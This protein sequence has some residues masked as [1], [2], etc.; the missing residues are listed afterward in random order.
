LSFDISIN[1]FWQGDLQDHTGLSI[2]IVDATN[3]GWNPSDESACDLSTTYGHTA[4]SRDG[5]TMR[6][7]NS[8]TPIH[9]TIDLRTLKVPLN[10]ISQL[11]WSI[12]PGMQGITVNYQITNIQ[13][14]D[15]ATTAPA[16]TP[17][18]TTPTPKPTQTPVPTQTPAPT[19]AAPI[20]PT[21]APTQP[22]VNNHN[23]WNI[24]NWSYFG[25]FH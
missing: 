6:V 24:L 14:S 2:I 9:Y 11:V 10:H 1:E 16:P 12:R 13:V 18:T 8:A 21:V 4:A 5:L 7:A 23:W 25:G 17:T 22:P 20:A 15:S 19:K 3:N